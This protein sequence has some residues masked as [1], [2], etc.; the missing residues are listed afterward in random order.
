MAEAGYA[1]GF[2]V[3]LNCPNDRYLN[4]E[5]ICQAFVG[6]LGRIGMT[7]TWSASRGR[8]TSR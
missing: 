4:D 6:M 8:C 1:D 3:D 7:P 5:A 2:S